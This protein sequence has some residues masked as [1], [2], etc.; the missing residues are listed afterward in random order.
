MKLIL[1]SAL[2]TIVSHV[3]AQT[4]GTE[5]SRLVKTADSLYRKGDYKNSA[6]MYSKAFRSAGW[7]GYAT[8]RYNAA[9]SWALASVKDSA[10]SN[11]ERIVA[12]ANYS[13]YDHITSDTDLEGLRN[14]PRWKPL[15]ERVKQNKDKEEINFNK[16]L[17]RVL[18]SLVNE[19]QNRRHQLTAFD[20]NQLNDKNVTRTSL[21]NAMLETDSLNYSLLSDIVKTYGFPNFDLVGERGSHNFWLLIQHQDRNPKFQEEVLS[22]MKVEVDNKK[23]SPGD[24][25]YLIDRVK[26]NTGQLQVYGTQMQL[27]ATETSYEPKPVIEPEKLNE[28]RRSVGLSSI[29]EYTESMNSHYFGTLKKK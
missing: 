27:N 8:D 5:Y 10:F 6:S 13:N 4:L 11:L 15:I 12:R 19:D 9:C 21:I 2:I 16:K 1:I 29:E 24:Y 14:D 18:D 20:N 26:V 17:I 23:A 28:R 3:A 22:K 25:A 7:K